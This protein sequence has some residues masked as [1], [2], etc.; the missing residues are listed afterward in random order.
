MIPLRGQ[1]VQTSALPVSALLVSALLL[2]PFASQA[3]VK[4][5]PSAGADL[6]MGSWRLDKP[7]SKIGNDPGVKSKEIVIAPSSGGGTITETLEMNSGEGGR[8][9]TRLTF[10]YGK[11]VAQHRPDIDAFCVEKAGPHRIFWTARHKGKPVGRLQ[12]DLSKDGQQL[13]FRY[14]SSAADPTGKVTSDRYVYDRE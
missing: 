13:T 1:A 7:K 6:F 14:L 5:A 4:N 8:Q 10:T 3:A 9:V 12:V 2:L 11:F